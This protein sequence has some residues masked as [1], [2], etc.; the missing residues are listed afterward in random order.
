MSRLSDLANSI[1]AG[2][3]M[4]G[5][6]DT[7]KA[8]EEAMPRLV[9]EDKDTLARE[10]LWNRVNNAA[11]K[12]KR[13]MKL[14]GMQEPASL[15]LFPDLNPRYSVDV[16][17]RQ[18]VLTDSLSQMEFRRVID[19]RQKQIKADSAHLKVLEDAYKA[20][21]PFWDANPEF[22]F[23]EICRVYASE[24]APKRGRSA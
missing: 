7:H 1:V 17:G 8:I 21:S 3:D 24:P 15:S 13:T 16:D 6:M 18:I 11:A 20:V 23:G 9:D 12:L 4:F 22:S 10:A 19:I 2:S 14:S 5:R